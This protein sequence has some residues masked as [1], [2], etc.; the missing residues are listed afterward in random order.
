MYRSLFEL[1]IAFLDADDIWLECHIA[2]LKDG[3]QMYPEAAIIANKLEDVL[4]GEYKEAATAMECKVLKEDVR[5]AA[6]AYLLSLSND[7][8][9]LHIGSTMYKKSLLEVG[10]IRF[11][12]AMKLGEDVNFMIRVSRWGE[13]ML[14]DYT[15]FV[16]CHDDEQSAMHGAAKNA[17]LTPLY[18][19]GLSMQQCTSE[20]YKQIM[21][22]LRREY[23][24]KAYQNRGLA[25]DKDE[26]STKVGGGVEIGKRMAIVYL[27][28][29]YTPSVII[30][31]AHMLKAK[32]SV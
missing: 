10:H 31:L 16:Y 20:E 23:M 30:S 3:F 26:L 32:R 28:I 13:C 4:N 7:Q 15:G 8:F 11:D 9:P 18:F 6:E 19:N 21:K 5:Y 14:S 2:L 1:S 22:F 24:K 12:E 25:F 27:L 17:V 29:R